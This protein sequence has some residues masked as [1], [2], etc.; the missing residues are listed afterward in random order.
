MT[1][2]RPAGLLTHFW[3]IIYWWEVIWLKRAKTGTNYSQKLKLRVPT[4]QTIHYKPSKTKCTHMTEQK[5][6]EQATNLK[7]II[8]RT[9]WALQNIMTHIILSLQKSSHKPFWNGDLNRYIA[10]NHI[11]ELLQ[12]CIIPNQSRLCW[13][14]LIVRKFER[15]KLNM[16]N[17]IKH[18]W[19]LGMADCH[20]H[21]K[22]KHITLQCQLSLAKWCTCNWLDTTNCRS[23]SLP[24]HWVV[25]PFCLQLKATGAF[26][27]P[28]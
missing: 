14:T 28:I 21:W 20:L 10:V 22:G 19:F 25:P 6:V 3:A 24:I 15:W 13:D 7:T 12:P 9:K 26:C 5:E 4:I 17:K 8:A 16:I 27:K 2:S 11:V 1:G 23:T 18:S